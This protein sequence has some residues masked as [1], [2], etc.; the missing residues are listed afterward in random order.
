MLGLRPRV[1]RACLTVP[2]NSPSK[3]ARAASTDA[4]EVILDLEDSI[5]A[6]QKNDRTR[7]LVAAAVA[8]SEWRA[9]TVAVRV[10]GLATPWFADDI[11]AMVRLAGRRLASLVLPKVETADDVLTAAAILDQLEADGTT[12][13]RVGLE[14]QIETALGLVNVER[15]ACASPRLEALVFGPGDFAASMGMPMGPIGGFDET[16]P[17]DQWLYARSRIAVAARAFDLAPIDGPY[18]NFRDPDGLRESARRARILGF[19]GKWAIHP[20]QIVVCN[21]T[22]SPS[23]AE[24]KAAEDAIAAL[25]ESRGHGAGVA[26]PGGEMMDEAIRRAAEGARRTGSKASRA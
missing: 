15:I 12:M 3:L 10:N 7:A 5:P 2:G 4:D 22:F 19:A 1:R 18:A 23:D 24:L 20:V 26:A 17:G 8:G 9:P 16:Y 25:E 14:A 11:T 6:E 21:E 13:V